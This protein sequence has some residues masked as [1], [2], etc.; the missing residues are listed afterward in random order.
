MRTI[1]VMVLKFSHRFSKG[2][3]TTSWPDLFLT[4]TGHIFV[5]SS[6]LPQSDHVYTDE[7]AGTTPVALTEP[8][9]EPR[10]AESSTAWAILGVRRRYR[11]H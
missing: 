1:I 8:L 10:E 3:A 2:F 6:R 9:K 4:N 5:K 11:Y 7:S